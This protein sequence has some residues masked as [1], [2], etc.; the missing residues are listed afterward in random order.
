MVG[1]MSAQR[2]PVYR[3]DSQ[4]GPWPLGHLVSPGAALEIKRTLSLP[5][6]L[7]ML[8]LSE[9]PGMLGLSGTAMSQRILLVHPCGN[10]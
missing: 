9:F 6:L 5:P 1:D 7:D 3:W 10:G 8:P 2:Y 4:L